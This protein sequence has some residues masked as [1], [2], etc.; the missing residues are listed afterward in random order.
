V[1]SATLLFVTLA[2]LVVLVALVAL[3]TRAWQRAARSRLARRRMA[4]A[5]AGEQ[6]AIAL[7]E[8][9]GFE[10]LGAQV[11]TTYELVVDGAAHDVKVRADYVVT[12]GGL[13]YV[14]EV[15][16]GELAPRIDTIATRRQLLEYRV[17]FDVEGVLLVDVESA[18]VREVIF[19]ATRAPA[20]LAAASP[21]AWLPWVAL[22]SICAGT[23][24]S[25]VWG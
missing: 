7:L 13:A 15:K 9:H 23:F 22:G 18:L 6:R 14:A 25:L 17:A 16:T 8:T 3:A 4:R 20:Q 19:P 10:L 24:A 11:A 5:T 2:G 21:E 1:T 12:R